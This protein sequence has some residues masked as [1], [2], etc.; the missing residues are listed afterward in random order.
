MKA[1]FAL[2]LTDVDENALVGGICLCEAETLGGFGNDSSSHSKSP[3]IKNSRGYSLLAC[4]WPPA[5]ML[6][7]RDAFSAYT[8]LTYIERKV[9]MCGPGAPRFPAA[10]PVCGNDYFFCLPWLLQQACE[11]V[12]L[13]LALSSM[14]DDAFPP[15]REN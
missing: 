5:V 10:P 13:L 8:S 7:R 3:E 14:Q 6:A 4:E 9:L 15:I 12:R 1:S 2:N 11:T